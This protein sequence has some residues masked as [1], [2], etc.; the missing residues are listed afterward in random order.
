VVYFSA[1]GAG[2]EY[3]EFGLFYN[4][5]YVQNWTLGHLPAWGQLAFS[6]P[7]KAVI[8]VIAL[9]KI[10]LL[11]RWISRPVRWATGWFFL[12]LFASIL[13][14]RPYPHY[15]LQVL[16]PLVLTLGLVAHEMTVKRKKILS[17]F[18]RL[19]T[20]GAAVSCLAAV[21]V[22]WT[23][24]R[25]NHYP[26]VSYY[27]NYFRFLSGQLDPI[28]YRNSF[29]SYMSDNYMASQVLKSSS[30]STAFIWG[31]NPMLY[32]LSGKQ[33]VGRFTVAF[34]IQDL[35]LYDE[36]L[37]AVRA[38]RP[39]YIVVMKDERVPLPGLE[40]VLRSSYLPSRNYEHFAMWRRM[41]K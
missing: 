14:N 36:T 25:I 40:S 5:H 6:L 18:A 39:E 12:A 37:A 10:T 34:H 28:A 26:V 8:L 7:F 16:P 38:S 9:I 29:N 2:K 17:T 30:D 27:Q 3:L 23:A 1:I 13:S 41:Q 15:I 19:A 21:C 20:L 35:Q 31:T 22:I 11:S 32:A 24:L 33:P 4:F